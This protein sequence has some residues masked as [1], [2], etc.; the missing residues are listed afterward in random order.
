MVLTKLGKYLQ[1]IDERNDGRLDESYVVGIST[2]K[3]FIVT[4]ANLE[5]VNL[6]SYKVVPP[7]AFAYVADTSRRGDKVSLAYNDSNQE[8][9]V[10]SISTVFIVSN[11]AKL[12]SEFLFMFFN[13]PEFDRY[14][15]Y[16][17]WGSARETFSWK[18]MCDIEINLPPIS[19]QNKYVEVY[20]SILENQRVYE[21]GLD[22][23][24]LVCDATVEKLRREFP[25]SRLEPY[26]TRVDERTIDNSIKNVKGVSVK[27]I[28]RTPTSKVNVKELTNYKIVKPGEITFVQTTHNEKVFAYALNNTSENIVVS[29]VNEVFRTD[30]EKLLPEYLAQFFNRTEFD[31]Y[32]RFHSWGSARET[33]TWNDICQVRI[34]IPDIRIQQSIADIYN[35]YITRTEINERLKQHIKKVCPILIAGASKEASTND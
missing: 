3:E 7:K 1:I 20:Q 2:S 26:I 28:F 24:K 22:D 16:N 9:L 5:G 6:N 11:T 35:V 21:K 27:K 18:D 33:F 14:A 31:R 17:S 19:I 32:A 13:R 25:G 10:S 15:R 12:L 29:S 4:K 23:L 34:P 30:M 8:Y